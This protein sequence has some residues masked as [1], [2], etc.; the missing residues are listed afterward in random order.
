VGLEDD[1]VIEPKG[2]RYL[3]EPQRELWVL[4]K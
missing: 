1:V 4:G 2:A 3:G